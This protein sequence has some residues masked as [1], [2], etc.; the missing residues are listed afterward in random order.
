VT[1]RHR[2]EGLVWFALQ[3]SGIEVPETEARKLRAEATHIARDN[4][5]MAAEA[6]RLTA[7][8]CSGCVPLLFVKGL[9]LAKLAY[10]NISLKKGWDID[11][12][13][14]P[15]NVGDAAKLLL[16]LGYE[17]KVPAVA[18]VDDLHSWHALSKE[19][20]W[21]HRASGH[22]VELHTSLVNNPYLLSGVDIG[23][24]A[25]N[26]EV[27]KGVVLQTLPPD[28]L[29]AYLCVHGASSAWWR[30]KWLADL[31]ALA[32]SDAAQTERLYRRSQ[33]LG[34]GRAAAQAL[35]LA[36]DLLGMPLSATLE[37]AL[38]TSW[39]NRRLTAAAKRLM[40]G[41]MPAEELH[42]RRFGTWAIHWTQF[43]LLPS[44]PYKLR[45]LMR[46]LAD[47]VHRKLFPP[48]EPIRFFHPLL[49]SVRL[50]VADGRERG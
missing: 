30:L 23:S 33:E 28:E 15:K 16:E 46:Q 27:V 39:S 25:V 34:S 6:R 1:R 49:R 9:T 31:A 21:R 37:S 29:F 38:R 19:S 2:I 24:G 20:V 3:D 14:A 35:L 47:P 43:L 4:L 17:A 36:A 11:I 42:E 44:M 41:R 8:F 10:G 45:E 50:A 7:A 48:P 13:V 26:V 12:L 22:F 18:S 40:N 32:G 5:G